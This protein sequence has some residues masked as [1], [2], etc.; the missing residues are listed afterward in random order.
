[1]AEPTLLSI[2]GEVEALSVLFKSTLD[3]KLSGK[4]DVALVDEQVGKIQTDLFAK[5]D[6]GNALLKAGQTK[7]DV[8]IEAIK[9]A[10]LDSSGDTANADKIDYKADAKY[11]GL[12]ECA[13]G[14]RPRTDGANGLEKYAEAMS[15][16]NVDG[17]SPEVMGLLQL[18]K[19]PDGGFALVPEMERGITRRI[20]D[21]S[22]LRPFAR[23]RSLSQG[24]VWEAVYETVRAAA[25]WRGE[26]QSVPET[27]TPEMELLSI[28]LHELNSQPIATQWE[29]RMG[30]Q[31]FDVEDFLMSSVAEGQTIVEGDAFW[32]GNG[33]NKVRGITSYTT[34]ATGDDTR[35]WGEL[36][37]VVT[38]VSGAFAASPAQGDVFYDVLG[39]IKRAHRANSRWFM[40][41]GTM[42]TVMKFRDADGQYLWQIVLQDNGFNIRLAGYPVVED[43]GVPDIA[44]DSLSVAFG[45]MMRGYTIVDK[46]GIFIIRD[47]LTDKG[48]VIWWVSRYV[49]GAVSDFDAIKLIK[50][51][52]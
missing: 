13:G 17:I 4:A 27:D 39:T 51:S 9:Q 32:A 45:D 48:K 43:E 3:E 30:N 16:Y 36:Q 24:R 33:V 12:I 44:A 50:F 40:N 19:G 14:G 7:L 15:R 37:H 8:E 35:A 29:V 41:R 5:L 38:G 31:L 20:F 22:A 49:G 1:M 46:P 47:E 18:G 11:F 6:Q 10:A 34:V 42:A 28:P 25:G 21:V 26:L 23:K 52:T 2:Q